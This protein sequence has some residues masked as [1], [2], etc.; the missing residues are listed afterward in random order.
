MISVNVKFIGKDVYSL[1]VSGHANYDDYGKDIVCAGVSAIVT[2]GI[3]SIEEL[4]ELKNIKLIQESNKL[5]LEVVKNNDKLQ[6]II[7][8]IYYQLKTIEE[9]YKNFIKMNI[10]RGGV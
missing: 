3:N 9:S 4:N 7:Q 8:T 6:T 5:G 2:G 10:E 1:I